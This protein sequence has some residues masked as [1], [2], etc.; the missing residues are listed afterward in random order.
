[1]KNRL[2]IRVVNVQFVL[3]QLEKKQSSTTTFFTSL[4]L[5]RIG[6]AGHSLGGA[7]AGAAMAHD[8]RLKAAV[9]IDGTLYGGL[10]KSRGY[11]PFLVVESKKDDQVVTPDMK[12]AISCYSS[13]LVVGIDTS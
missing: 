8:A 1:M 2:D 7:T 10:P 3:D 9:N 5:N 4:D 6:I 11:C 13:T 12:Q